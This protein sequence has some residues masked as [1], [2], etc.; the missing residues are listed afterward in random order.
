MHAEAFL[1][2]SKMTYS[3][4]NVQNFAMNRFK[5]FRRVLLFL[6]I[7]LNIFLLCREDS[8]KES[9]VAEKLT[10][11]PHPKFELNRFD[12]VEVVD[13]GLAY[14]NVEKTF[15]LSILHVFEPFG[16]E[17]LGKNVRQGHRQNYR[18]LAIRYPHIELNVIYVYT[19]DDVDIGHHDVYKHDFWDYP[20]PEALV[21]KLAK[22]R[23]TLVLTRNTEIVRHLDG[24][25]KIDEPDNEADVQFINPIFY[26]C[27]KKCDLNSTTLNS[28][29]VIGR[30]APD[31]NKRHCMVGSPSN[32]FIL[33]RELLELITHKKRHHQYAL[34]GIQQS[35]FL[36]EWLLLLKFYK[37][38]GD[39]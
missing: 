35:C 2:N 28:G 25:E 14:E 10:Q 34:T 4:L 6:S 38:F 23:R 32:R 3:G 15:Q 13:P 22:F 18:N 29:L 39:K 12:V 20:W 16:N 37:L 33:N 19:Q 1:L 27:E 11:T 26:L 36:Q 5:L 21:I 7:F 17:E 31:Q 24:I 30:D 9:Q 8:P